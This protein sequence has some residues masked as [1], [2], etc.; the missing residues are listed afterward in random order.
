MSRLIHMTVALVG[1][2]STLNLVFFWGGMT[3]GMGEGNVLYYMWVARELPNITY[4]A[5]AVVVS[6]YV[7]LGILRSGVCEGHGADVPRAGMCT[8][9]VRRVDIKHYYTG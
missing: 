1:M 4:T 3:S 2:L 9:G 7:S 6:L 8:V 5:S